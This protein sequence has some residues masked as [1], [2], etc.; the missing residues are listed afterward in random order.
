MIGE[1]TQDD[2]ADGSRARMTTAMHML[3]VRV[4]VIYIYMRAMRVARALGRGVV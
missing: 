2:R 4:T 3:C 1:L